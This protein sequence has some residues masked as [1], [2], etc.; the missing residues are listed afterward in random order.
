MARKPR[1]NLPG[2]PQH[3]VQRGNN[4]EPCFFA[5]DDYHRYLHDLH[6]AARANKPRHSR[7]C[8]D[9]QSYAS[10]GH[11]GRGVWHYLP[12]A[13]CRTQIRSVR[14]PLLSPQ[15]YLVGGTVQH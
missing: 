11:A 15:R 9:E 4:R 2:V 3:I 7:L 5:V 14:Q 12:D 8:M 10:A 6:E 1:F 13:G